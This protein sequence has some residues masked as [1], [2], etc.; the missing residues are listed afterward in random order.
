MSLGAGIFFPRVRAEFCDHGEG[1]DCGGERPIT[2]IELWRNQFCC[3]CMTD[4]RSVCFGC[5]CVCIFTYLVMF[6]A[7]FLICVF[8]TWGSPFN[9]VAV[10]IGDTV[11]V[12]EQAIG[13]TY[14]P[15]LYL[16]PP[17]QNGGVIQREY[18]DSRNMQQYMDAQPSP[19]ITNYLS[20]IFGT[21]AVA[22]ASM[23]VASNAAQTR[24]VTEATSINELQQRNLATLNGGAEMATCRLDF[25]DCQSQS[26]WAY[27]GQVVVPWTRNSRNFLY[28]S[29]SCRAICK[30]INYGEGMP[31]YGACVCT[32]RPAV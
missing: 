6:F 25:D 10:P 31:G 11:V 17:Q 21:G 12:E 22:A 4:M 5:D 13:N 28:N 24:F 14:R 15:M 8:A 18:V 27:L 26:K 32:A 29:Q 23:N 16:P 2:L 1:C 30:P 3:R 9:F 20:T 19:T 7:L